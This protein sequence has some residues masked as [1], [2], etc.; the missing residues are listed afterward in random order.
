MSTS[1][2]I[3]LQCENIQ[4]AF[5]GLKAVA[6]VSRSFQSG[7]IYGLIGPNGA[8][9]TTLMNALS[10]HATL[11]AGQVTLMVDGVPIVAVLTSIGC[12][13][14]HRAAFERAFRDSNHRGARQPD[15]P[16]SHTRRTWRDRL[17][18]APLP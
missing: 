15:R 3:S 17:R 9:K 11:A 10:G 8:G 12:R 13:P 7:R 4:V 2:G 14:Q 5:G 18:G 1:N 6:G 16:R